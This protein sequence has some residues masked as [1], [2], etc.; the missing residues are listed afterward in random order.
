MMNILL[1]GAGGA[2]GAVSRHYVGQAALRTLGSGQ[3]WGTLA[4][5][6]LGGLL[7]GLLVGWLA[8]TER[9][10]A[11]SI[12]YLAAVGFLGGFTTFS[13]FSLE[14][15]RLIETRAW[16][17]AFGYATGSVVLSVGAVIVGLMIMRKVWA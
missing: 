11:T 13:A 12:R 2:L 14:M 5:N 3:P 17:N 9:A 1:I 7:M 4:V 6:I 10:D 16:L 8:A 15:V